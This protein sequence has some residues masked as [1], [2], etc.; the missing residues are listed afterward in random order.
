MS[1]WQ[2]LKR[3]NVFRVAVAYLIV[4]WLVIQVVSALSAPLNVPE[5]FDTVAV[6]LLAVGF[7]IAVIVAWAFELTP[8]G[9]RLTME[10]EHSGRSARTSGRSFD[11]LIIALLSVA[12][13][14]FTADKYV[15][16]GNHAE[17]QSAST[18]PVSTSDPTVAVLQFDNTSS[19]PGQD[20][21]A[22]GFSEELRAYLGR[23]E[24][25]TVAG[26]RSS[27]ALEERNASYSDIRELLGVEY[28]LD[29]S[30]DRAG[31]SVRARVSL[32]RTDSGFELWSHSF[33]QDFQGVFELYAQ[34]SSQVA[35]ELSLEL[36]LPTISRMPG[37]TRNPEAY[38]LYLQ[39]Y[40]IARQWLFDEI[41]TAIDLLET[42]VTVDPDFSQA[43]VLLAQAYIQGNSLGQND[44][45]SMEA[46]VQRA[47]DFA[48]ELA[49]TQ[50]LL[51]TYYTDRLRF[52]EARAA[53]ISGLDMDPVDRA[54]MLHFYG[55][56]LLTTGHVREALEY[57][58]SARSLDPLVMILEY[59]L[60]MAA[61][62]L[63]D[64]EQA[65]L[66]HQ[67]TKAL[68]GEH[69]IPE[70]EHIFRLAGLERFAD[71]REQILLVRALPIWRS[72]TAMDSLVSEL[73][74]LLQSP[75]AIQ[76]VRPR[77]RDLLAQEPLRASEIAQWAAYL[78][79]AETAVTALRSLVS[80][81]GS[82]LST[83]WSPRW[84]VVRASDS[85]AEF[86]IDIGLVDYWDEYG[87]PDKCRQTESDAFECF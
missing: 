38:D 1:F 32:I 73:S 68:T 23:L 37:G 20:Y 64:S 19:D 7:P 14:Y 47:I 18:T 45:A 42:A 61:D 2:E 85:F 57:L 28:V 11:Y 33:A 79:D 16:N 13:I 58:E 75:N 78:G 66:H 63:G 55:W 80:T 22:A 35:E 29:G 82:T 43:R 74:G 17:V 72:G 56:F 36:N 77:L 60:G 71:A 86:V 84:D 31:N 30:I 41:P 4:A 25:L 44:A 87:W 27:V 81:S 10:T 26:P 48:P 50:L 21:L 24:G 39:A 83:I 62:M 65:I 70:F 76:V 15:L 53:L 5:W 69:F 59:H 8:S 67:F 54:E 46:A 51:G 52:S 9:I 40:A 3:R 6:L 34:I 49:G 12:V